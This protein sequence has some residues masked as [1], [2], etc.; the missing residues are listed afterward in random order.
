M[1]VQDSI[2]VD[3]W[4]NPGRDDDFSDDMDFLRTYCTEAGLGDDLR[5]RRFDWRKASRQLLFMDAS[6]VLQSTTRRWAATGR[7]PTDY[8]TLRCALAEWVS[9][10]PEEEDI[11][12]DRFAMKRALAAAWFPACMSIRPPQVDDWEDIM[13]WGDTC[14]GYRWWTHQ[15]GSNLNWLQEDRQ[16]QYNLTGEWVGSLEELRAVQ[17]FQARAQRFDG[18]PPTREEQGQW[19]DLHNALRR[20]FDRRQG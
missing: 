15:G 10:G 9:Y 8:V 2:W 14:D 12:G 18:Y 3:V 17:F 16:R 19:M 4:L 13:R 20:A 5:P 6:W 7:Y 1:D 11:V